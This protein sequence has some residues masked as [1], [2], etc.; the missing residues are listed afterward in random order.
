MGFAGDDLKVLIGQI[1]TNGTLSGSV[2]VQIFPEGIQDPDIRLHLP[3]LYAPDQC[4]DEDACNYSPDAWLDTEC[5]YGP[6]AGEI[7]GEIAVILQEGQ[8]EW[9]YSCEA[10]AS[11]YS[12]EV[13]NG[14]TIVSGQGTNTII[15]DWG[16][17]VVS[18]TNI[19]VTASNE[20]GCEGEESS[21]AGF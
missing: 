10:G 13:G 2:Y 19:T 14:A 7:A 6:I 11:S 20:D 18:G 16:T 9:T 5:E 15:I 1:T 3:I 8:T 17:E 21:Q 4:M 12:W